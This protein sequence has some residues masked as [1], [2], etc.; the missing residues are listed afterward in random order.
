VRARPQLAR[1]TCAVPH[2]GVAGSA[3]N[4]ALHL[5]AGRH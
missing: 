2:H 5:A 3:A 4:L 1:A